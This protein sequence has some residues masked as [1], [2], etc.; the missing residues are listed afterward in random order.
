[1]DVDPQINTH[2]C[3]FLATLSQIFKPCHA[4]LKV[5]FNKFDIN[6][7]QANQNL[8]IYCT[9][10]IGLCHGMPKK[11]ALERLFQPKVF[12]THNDLQ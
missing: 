2:I 9:I 6:V 7:M 3:P 12:T 10:L 5:C 4:L 11:G 1:M 8:F